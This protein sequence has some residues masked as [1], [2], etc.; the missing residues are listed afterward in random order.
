MTSVCARVHQRLNFLRRLRLVGVCKHIMLNFYRA[1]IESIF[2]YGMTSWFGNLTV[3]SKA[4]I[5][6]LVRTA[7]KIMGTPAPLNPQELFEQAICRQARSIL[8]DKTHVL[9][10]EYRLMNS[11]RRF[12]VPLCRYNR[13]KY[14]FIPLSV[15]C[16]NDQKGMYSEGVG[17]IRVGVLST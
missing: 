11:G 8:S 4:Q 17:G 1:A 7:G 10:P 9:Y 2:R 6:S 13:Y 16:L 3:K 14:Y 5:S 12:R 15:K